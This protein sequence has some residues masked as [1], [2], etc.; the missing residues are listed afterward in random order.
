ME[1]E[2]NKISDAEYLIMQVLWVQ[3]AS[4]SQDIIEQVNRSMSWAPTTV[5]TLLKRLADK[6]FVQVQRQGKRYIYLPLIS[7]HDSVVSAVDSLLTH[8]CSTKMGKTIA[9]IIKRSPLTHQDIAQL[10]KLIAQKK[11]EA[12]DH[13]TCNCL[14]GLC[15]C[16]EHKQHKA[17]CSAHQENTVSKSK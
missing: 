13:V 8:I 6:G 16:Q 15:E 11:K 7:Q 14:P 10:E 12:V 9:E 2:I 17:T 4:P 1:P 3:G 5:R